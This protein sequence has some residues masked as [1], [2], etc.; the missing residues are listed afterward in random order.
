MKHTIPRLIMS[1]GTLIVVGCSAKDSGQ[2]ADAP[3]ETAYRRFALALVSPKQSE[4]S[5]LILDNSDAAIL[6]EGAYPAPVAAA[7]TEQYRTMQI[8]RDNT[9]DKNTPERVVLSSSAIPSLTV[10]KV[11]GHWK[12]DAAPL[13]RIRKSVKQFA[14]RRVIQ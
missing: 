7:L 6:W 5:E 13:I 4:I 14:T 2:S 12:V 3:P 10:L 8:T 9:N 11:D 1:I